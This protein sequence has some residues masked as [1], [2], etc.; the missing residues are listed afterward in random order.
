[1]SLFG[2]GLGVVVVSDKCGVVSSGSGSV[3]LGALCN[4]RDGPMRA[5]WDVMWCCAHPRLRL[6]SIHRVACML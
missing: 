4:G 3:S 2:Y 6:G 5:R 1:M